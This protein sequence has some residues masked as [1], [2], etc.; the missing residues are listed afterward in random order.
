MCVMELGQGGSA[1]QEIISDGVCD[2]K[3]RTWDAEP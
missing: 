2:A 1:V 3:V